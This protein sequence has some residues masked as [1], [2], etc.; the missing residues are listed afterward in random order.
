MAAMR[1]KSKTQEPACA[2][3][4]EQRGMLFS[5]GIGLGFNTFMIA[6]EAPPP[7]GGLLGIKPSARINSI[8]GRIKIHFRGFLYGFMRK[9][10]Q[11]AR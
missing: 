5:K 1:P 11:T 10:Q 8:S 9:A 6:P 2:G 4:A 7:E 3:E